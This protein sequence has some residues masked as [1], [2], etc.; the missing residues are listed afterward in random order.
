MKIPAKMPKEQKRFY[1]RMKEIH[2]LPDP[3]DRVKLE[4]DLE[5]ILAKGGDIS[6]L[7]K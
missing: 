4:K 3:P 2:K 6:Q 1:Q 7:I 5:A